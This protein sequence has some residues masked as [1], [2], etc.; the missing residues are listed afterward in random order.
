MAPDRFDPTKEAVLNPW[1][2]TKP[3]FYMPKIGITCFSKKLIDRICEVF[4]P[5]QIAYL[6]NANGRVPV[7]KLNY[8]GADIALYMS[9]VGSASCA[10]AYEDI[11]EMGL[12]KL[13]MFGSCGVLSKDIE[14]LSI[15]IPNLALRDEGVS[16]HY[17]PY[18]RDISVNEKYIDEFKQI[19]DE[20]GY[21]YTEGKVWTTDAPYRETRDKV[22]RYKSEG[23]I[24]VDMECAAMSAVAK[25]RGKEFFQFFYAADNLDGVKWDK[26][27]LGSSGDLSEK[28]KVVLPAL[29]LALKMI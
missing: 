29:E 13:V 10:A 19:L 3:V 12:E 7:Y 14:D 20:H 23:C 2:T 5:E 22:E 16:F 25:F 11:L 15:I 8:K 4:A 6:K 26:R 27:S 24:C 21:T 18:S 17:A 9:Y 28:E 1:N